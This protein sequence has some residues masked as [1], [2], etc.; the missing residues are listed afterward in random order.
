MREEETICLQ[1]LKNSGEYFD[2]FF[3]F[4]C[5]LSAA[6]AA[7]FALYI[8]SCVVIYERTVRIVAVVEPNTC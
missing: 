8:F 4:S 1:N 2:F 7:I 5:I 6:G 3:F